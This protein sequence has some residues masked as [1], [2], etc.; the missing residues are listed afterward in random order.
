MSELSGVVMIFG[1]GL[2]MICAP[3]VFLPEKAMRFVK[4][5]PRNKAIGMALTAVALTWSAWL[6]MKM[7]MGGLDKWKP[8]LYVLT[9]L[10]FIL[11]VLLV[12]ELLAARALGGLL[13]LVPAPILTAA[14]WHASP[15]RLVIVILSYLLVVAGMIL[16]L[17]PF[18]FRK[19]MAILAANQKNCRITGSIGFAL[20]ILVICLGLT[21]LA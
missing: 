17:S 21:V 6:L 8:L 12:D 9:P 2:A 5:F 4:A 18:R 20:G 16:V 13:L 1:A 10:T 15:F 7:D 19:T 11:V 14:Q 3:L